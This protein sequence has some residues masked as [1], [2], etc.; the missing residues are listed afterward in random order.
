[1]KC[2]LCQH[3][4]QSAELMT[5]DCSN[6][7]LKF[8]NPAI[9]LSSDDE[10]TRYRH[11]NNDP[12]DDGYK[13]FLSKLLN[14]L[15]QYLQPHFLSLDFGS[16]PGPTLSLL[17]KEFVEAAYDYDPLFHPDQDLLNKKYDV[18]TSTEV[19]E[20]FKTP[21]SD[22]DIM[23]NLVKPGGYLAVMTQVLNP[24]TNYASWWY[25]NDPTHVVFYKAETFD[26]LAKKY[27]MKKVFNDNLSVVIFKKEED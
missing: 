22:W 5:F 25:K 4:A 2:L 20:H 7:G 26:F 10:S 3:S 15:K 18:V 23:A 9:F 1:M 17:M 11:H 21:Q 27:Q 16:G 6:C 13:K 14:P 24:E 8:K 19:V 12:T